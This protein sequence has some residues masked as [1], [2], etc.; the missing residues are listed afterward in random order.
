MVEGSWEDN[1]KRMK[2][3]VAGVQAK[4]QAAVR[5]PHFL[6]LRM[7][8]CDGRSSLVHSIQLSAAISVLPA[9]M[10]LLCAQV[11]KAAELKQRLEDLTA[12]CAE[13]RDTLPLASELRVGGNVVRT[14]PR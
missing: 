11:D 13:L 9:R 6:C 10:P 5:S 14:K 7:H 12:R 3:G 8:P 1:T 4:T 2:E